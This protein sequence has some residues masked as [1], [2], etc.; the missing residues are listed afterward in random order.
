MPTWIARCSALLAAPIMAGGV[1]ALLASVG[2][3]PAALSA[4]SIDMSADRNASAW[5]RLGLQL[6]LFG[7]YLLLLP[8]AA[9]GFSAAGRAAAWGPLAGLCGAGYILAGA[10]GAAALAS[11]WPVLLDAAR[12][13]EEID[14]GLFDALGALVHGGLWNGLS[15]LLGAAWWVLC[16]VD[17]FYERRPLM[18]GASLLLATGAALSGLGQY[19]GLEPIQGIGLG[20]YLTLAPAWA[21]LVF[22]G[23]PA[24]APNITSRGR[25]LSAEAPALE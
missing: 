17:A 25:R 10:V 7:Y 21:L 16:A 24:F 9:Q 11:T 18:C 20:L 13:G 15:I 2:F 19:V 23:G 22:V 14:R 3:D 5:L 1:I 12:A 4:P 8:A 6:D